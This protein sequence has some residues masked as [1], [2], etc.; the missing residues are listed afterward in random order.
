MELP[1]RDDREEIR[2]LDRVECDAV[3]RHVEP[4]EYAALDRA[5]YV[6]AFGAGLRHGELCGLRIMDVD[7]L[8]GRIRVRQNWVLDEYGTPKSRRSS[9]S[10]PMTKRVAGE[11][12][13]LLQGR[14][15]DPPAALVFP[16]PHTGEPM[17]KAKTLRRFRRTLKAAGVEA[18]HTL[19]DLR[20]T[21]GTQMAA[22]GVPMRTL[23]EW[24]GHKH[25][26]TTERYADYAPSTHESDLI[27]TASAERALNLPS[28]SPD[29]SESES[30]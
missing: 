9:R 8:A 23:Q 29:L 25:I 18:T 26:T 30:T 16:D 10:V 7:W 15:S 14:E 6:T 28:I 20:H 24:M 4:G 1:D 21:F 12:A 22:G 3:V 13:R 27:E 19:H 17:S 2:F 11:L 5:L